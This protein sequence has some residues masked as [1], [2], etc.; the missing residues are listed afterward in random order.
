M[1]TEKE[2]RRKRAEIVARPERMKSKRM[3][4][5][6]ELHRC[7]HPTVCGILIQETLNVIGWKFYTYYI[8]TTLDGRVLLLSVRD[9]YEQNL[10]IKSCNAWCKTGSGSHVMWYPCNSISCMHT[11]H[12]YT[13]TDVHTYALLPEDQ[14]EG[15]HKDGQEST[16][17]EEN[18]PA[19]QWEVRYWVQHKETIT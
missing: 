12:T 10:T 19:C 18:V 2:R 6:T 9:T 8:S 17:Q 14:V 5:T 11:Q 15:S 4:V 13:D 16:L 1:S 7:F 3:L